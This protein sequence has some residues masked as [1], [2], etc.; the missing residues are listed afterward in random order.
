VHV[1]PANRRFQLEK[2]GEHFIRPHDD[3]TLS[4]AMRVNNSDRSPFKIERR[5]PAQDKSR[6]ADI[7][8]DDFQYFTASACY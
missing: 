5:D 7:L 3:E 2:R 6:L 4:V 8:S 1:R